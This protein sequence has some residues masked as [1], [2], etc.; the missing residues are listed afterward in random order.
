MASGKV[1]PSKVDAS[2]GDLSLAPT[3]Q[4]QRRVIV[5]RGDT[6][7]RTVGLLS[8]TEMLHLLGKSDSLPSGSF[9]ARNV[10]TMEESSH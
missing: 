2:A 9:R 3:A 5:D 10:P 8:T 1:A 6:P 7:T 4:G